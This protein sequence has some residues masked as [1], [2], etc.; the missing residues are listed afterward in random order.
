M[1]V[2]SGSSKSLNIV[3][4]TGAGISRESGLDTFRD[5]DGIWAKVNVDDVATPEGFARNPE[6]AHQF[7][8]SLRNQLLSDAIRPNAAHLALA[9]LEREWD[10]KVLLV[11][12]NVDDLHERAGSANLIHMHGELLKARCS[13]CLRVITCNENLSVTTACTG[14]GLSGSMR[15]HIV[16]FGE[17]PYAMSEINQA[18]K[19]CDIF[20]AVG[21]S[22][23]V[24]PAA[25][26]V[27]VARVARAHTV[28][29]NLEPSVGAPRFHERIYG[30]A[31]IIVT[32]YVERFL[33]DHKIAKGD[34]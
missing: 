34:V 33:K 32:E 31:T 14:C 16:F 8:N 15:P 21:T 18:V 6:R 5:T 3:I 4:L 24:Y 25:G 11:T 19:E 30:P 7:Y 23:N 27:E 20:M 12:Q 26:L 28:E 17:F 22:G 29:L 1:S 13:N 2:I 10:G 9:N